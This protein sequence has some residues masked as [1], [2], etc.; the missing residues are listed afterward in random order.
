MQIQPNVFPYSQSP[1]RPPTYTYVTNVNLNFDYNHLSAASSLQSLNQGW[2]SYL[3]GGVSHFQMD[4]MLQMIMGLVQAMSS[5][6]FSQ[7]SPEMAPP[8]CECYNVEQQPSAYKEEFKPYKAEPKP[9]PKSEPKPQKEI[10][11]IQDEISNW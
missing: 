4:Q 5:Q 9:Q 8:R 6:L 7:K 10:D 2:Q 3:G 11:P 1:N